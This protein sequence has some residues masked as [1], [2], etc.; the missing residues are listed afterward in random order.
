MSFL[1]GDSD[2]KGDKAWACFGSDNLENDGKT[3][4]RQ[5]SFFNFNSESMSCNNKDESIFK[6]PS[7]KTSVSGQIEGK[8][9][10]SPV[11]G[12]VLEPSTKTPQKTRANDP[13]AQY[14]SSTFS[15]SSSP[16][17]KKLCLDETRKDGCSPVSQVMIGQESNGQDRIGSGG[18]T[19]ETSGRG[20]NIYREG[21]DTQEA[22]RTARNSQEVGDMKMCGVEDKT[23]TSSGVGSMC[24]SSETSGVSGLL[25][26][27][28]KEQQNK[29]R[30][31]V[32]EVQLEENKT[33]E[34]VASMEQIVMDAGV[35]REQLGR[36]KHMYG[37]RLNQVLG[38][39]NL[40]GK[41]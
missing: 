39:L 30:D 18:D 33:E 17:K 28:M 3:S 29:M 2:D 8:T 7:V 5:D 32:V 27:L 4:T 9:L 16:L 36:I 41:Q 37:D 24:V 38:F 14:T 15:S 23:L 13:E 1:F 31:L 12:I 35:Y 34:L 40:G 22:E 20:D 6:T 21:M 19:K 25:K 10:L 26:E 11:K